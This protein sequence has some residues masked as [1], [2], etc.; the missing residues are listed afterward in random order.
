VECGEDRRFPFL[1]LGFGVCL[2]GAARLRPEHR[3]EENAKA[4]MLAAL[5]GSAGI[6]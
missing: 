3:K 5:Q 2:A 1:G 6:G 4:A